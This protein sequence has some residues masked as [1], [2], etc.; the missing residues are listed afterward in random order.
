MVRILRVVVVGLLLFAS[1]SVAQ[2]KPQEQWQGKSKMG[3]KVVDE[4]GK[5]V[6][7]ARVKLVFL[8]AKS[9]PETVTDK[10]GQ[11]KS[12]NIADGMW[13]VEY[14]KDGL[15]PRQISVEVGGKLKNPNIDM[16]MTKE[17]TEGGFALQT[18]DMQA[19]QLF[20]DGKFAEARA[21][22]EQMLVKYPKTHPLHA[23]IARS[24]H[25]EKN[26][27][28]AAEQLQ[29]YLADDPA[30]PQMKMLLGSELVDSEQTAEAWQVYSSIDPSAIKEAI[31]IETP[32]FTLLR[33]KKPVDALKYFNLA[34]TRFPQDPTGYYYRG[35]ANWQAMAALPKGD[36]PERKALL[37][38]AKADLTK[39]LEMSPTAP[40][41]GTAKQ[42]LAELNK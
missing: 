9:G 8:P 16:K 33:Q 21:I 38:Q 42:I 15:D 25:M 17:G 24:F 10:K 20:K 2:D 41:A 40:E 29:L 23:L 3:G 22:Y 1:A 30:N 11:W 18:G 13:Y 5:P 12:E 27:A 39:F 34:V 4:A 19:Q 37:D 7:G 35:F 28:K 26:C 6:E 14:Y 32:G 31:D 36:S